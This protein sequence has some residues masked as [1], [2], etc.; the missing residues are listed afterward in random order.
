MLI[1]RVIENVGTFSLAATWINLPACNVKRKSNYT[2]SHIH[3]CIRE[4]IA[5]NLPRLW[6]LY[7]VI[8]LGAYSNKI[9]WCKNAITN[10]LTCNRSAAQNLKQNKKTS[11]KVT[12]YNIDFRHLKQTFQLF[13]INFFVC[14]WKSHRSKKKKR[15]KHQELITKK[16]DCRKNITLRMPITNKKNN[17]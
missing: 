15:Q 4:S 6:Q 16:T 5:V 1:K 9:T 11:K 14:Y 3:A 2:Q 13:F 12:F 7:G 10:N 17:L 8:R